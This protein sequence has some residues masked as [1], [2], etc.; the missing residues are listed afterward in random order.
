MT[1]RLN[2]ISRVL[3][4]AGL[5][6]ALSGCNF[7]TRLANIG[8]E[9]PLSQIE[10]PVAQKGYQPVS[11]PM[12]RP[13]PVL[14][15]ANSLWRPGSKAFFKDQRANQVGDI[16]TVLVEIEDKATLNNSTD[17]SRTTSENAGFAGLLGLESQVTKVLP[18]G[19]SASA[20]VDLGSD[21][22]VSGSGAVNRNETINMEIAA[23]VTQILPNGNMVIVGRQEVRVNFESRDLSVTGVV[24][25]EDI[26]S[27]NTVQSSKIAEARI[28]Y[29][30][31]GHLTD[32]QQG[33]YGQQLFDIIFPF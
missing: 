2:T 18:E 30:G 11:M 7:F 3:L 14:Q 9:P 16:V 33:R 28:A 25:P 12:P 8:E 27:S 24:R 26:T 10:N 1:T 13:E 6:V 15:Q 29:G 5:G 22:S 21:H 17:T 32:V 23:I 4:V 19:T 20:L 31:R